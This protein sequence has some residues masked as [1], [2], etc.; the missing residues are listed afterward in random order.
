MPVA[1]RKKNRH[2][3]APLPENFGFQLFREMTIV[4]AMSFSVASSCYENPFFYTRCGKSGLRRNFGGIGSFE[5]PREISL[6]SF[7]LGMTHFDPANNYGPPSGTAV[8]SFG[9]VPPH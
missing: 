1:F 9:K 8:S 5:M 6:R 3:D 7:E 4:T 2:G